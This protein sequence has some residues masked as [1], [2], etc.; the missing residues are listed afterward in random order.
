MTDRE[1]FITNATVIASSIEDPSWSRAR[2]YV[3]QLGPIGGLVS[4]CIT[5]LR[6]LESSASNNRASDL[7][8]L[9]ILYRGPSMR[10]LLYFYAAHVHNKKLNALE[11]LAQNSLINLI[12][13]VELAA[14]VGVTYLYRR[15][16][17]LCKEE[18]WEKQSSEIKTQIESAVT[19][20]HALPEISVARSLLFGAIRPIALTILSSPTENEFKLY[21]RHFLKH[22]MLWDLREEEK[23]FGCNHLQIA[24]IL[25]QRLGFGPSCSLA[26]SSGLDHS[27]SEHADLDLRAKSWQAA[28]IWIEAILVQEQAPTQYP[29]GE[30]FSLDP[31]NYKALH[32]RIEAIQLVAESSIW[33][34]QKASDL[35]S[36]I[37]S[38]IFQKF[39][40]E[41]FVRGSQPDS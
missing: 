40:L 28:G 20:G 1:A 29:E 4:N 26:L 5:G 41:A 24:S 25:V 30:P 10:A 16:A 37:E 19:I 23:L 36:E 11:K 35:P 32:E 18:I 38:Q 14:L 13:P 7:A 9:K 34:T 39:P 6:R 21:R 27:F 8:A 17:R 31:D 2:K 22:N 3:D 33:L 15:L 12:A